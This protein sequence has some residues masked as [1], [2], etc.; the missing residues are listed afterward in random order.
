MPPGAKT[1]PR[2]VPGQV[3][4]E[5]VF[6][7]RWPSTGQREDGDLRAGSRRIC[8]CRAHMAALRYRREK[9]GLKGLPALPSRVPAGGEQGCPVRHTLDS[10]CSIPSCCPS[11]PRRSVWILPLNSVLTFFSD[12]L[13]LSLLFLLTS[14]AVLRSHPKCT[15]AL[16]SL[17]FNLSVRLSFTC[18][19]FLLDEF[20]ALFLV[21]KIS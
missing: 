6:R 2:I 4:R 7:G 5:R 3:G 21:C 1:P 8:R 14:E 18:V 16:F 17:L 19:P 13:F 20:T 15:H 9:G 12:F 10:S 11:L